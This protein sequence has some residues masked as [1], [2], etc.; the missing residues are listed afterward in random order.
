MRG[1]FRSLITSNDVKGSASIVKKDQKRIN[2]LTR[3]FRAQ[4]F[5]SW[6]HF[7]VIF[8]WGFSSA[9]GRGEK[10][11]LPIENHDFVLKKGRKSDLETI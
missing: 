6:S 7:Q 11:E 10:S 2:G 5:L 8:P 1:I 3:A 4:I 9:P